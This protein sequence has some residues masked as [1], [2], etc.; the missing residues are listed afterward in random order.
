[1][2]RAE[3]SDDKWHLFKEYDMIPKH[4]TRI[5]I[6]HSPEFW[7]AVAAGAIVGASHHDDHITIENPGITQKDVENL[8]KY[9]K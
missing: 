6:W 9:Y 5:T 8:K 4:I 1:L 2:I 3:L 7:G